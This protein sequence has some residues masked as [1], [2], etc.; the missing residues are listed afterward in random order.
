[1]CKTFHLQTGDY[2]N[3]S[4]VSDYTIADHLKYLKMKLAKELTGNEVA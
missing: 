2:F 1:M 4:V 3:P